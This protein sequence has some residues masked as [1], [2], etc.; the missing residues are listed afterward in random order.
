MKGTGNDNGLL[1]IVLFLTNTACLSP[2]HTRSRPRTAL[3][4]R[5]HR[6][7]CPFA[8]TLASVQPVEAET[9]SP[10]SFSHH[11]VRPPRPDASVPQAYKD[12]PTGSNSTASLFSSH[13]YA[14]LVRGSL[15]FSSGSLRCVVNTKK[16]SRCA[17][18]HAGYLGLCFGWVPISGSSRT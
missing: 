3:P 16:T 5:L 1:P 14:C 13:S 17:S 10:N 4:A 6:A 9:A 15:D 7:S 12:P 2:P 8:S 11:R 18:Y